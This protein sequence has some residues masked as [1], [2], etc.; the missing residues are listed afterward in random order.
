MSGRREEMIPL[1]DEQDGASSYGGAKSPSTSRDLLKFACTLLIVA[2][3]VVV[4]FS[5]G[6]FTGYSALCTRRRALCPSEN[7]ASASE[8]LGQYVDDVSVLQWLDGELKPGNIKENL[9]FSWLC[10]YNNLAKGLF[11]ILGN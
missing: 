3:L 8:N 6:L 7:A 4:I 2:F 11:I 5:G 1:R 9:R 10:L